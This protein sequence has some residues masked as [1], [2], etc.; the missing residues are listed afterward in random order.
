MSF[1]KIFKCEICDFQSK[2]FESHKE[3]FKD[4]HEDIEFT[5]GCIFDN[6]DYESEMPAD[7]VKYNTTK[8]KKA[9]EKIIRN[10][11]K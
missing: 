2:G 3:H 5:P 7:L 4:D 11:Q 9:N 6:C 1:V 8:H 10:N